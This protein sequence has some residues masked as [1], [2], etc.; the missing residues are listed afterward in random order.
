MIFIINL[1]NYLKLNTKGFLSN[2]FDIKEDLSL[3]KFY[4]TNYY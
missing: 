3:D 4:H 2:Y 1:D